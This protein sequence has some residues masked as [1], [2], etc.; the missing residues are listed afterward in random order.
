[1]FLYMAERLLLEF[2]N[3]EQEKFLNNCSLLH[4]LP[5]QR[6]ERLVGATDDTLVKK[7]KNL[8]RDGDS[9][10]FLT[11][12]RGVRGE[13]AEFAYPMTTG[14]KLR[15]VSRHAVKFEQEFF[16]KVY[17]DGVSVEDVGDLP[18]HPWKRLRRVREGFG[19]K[20]GLSLDER[21]ALRFVKEFYAERWRGL[22]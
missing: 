19:G 7:R 14:E 1:M 15:L 12:S 10:S 2:D 11:K 20:L 6:A 16:H 8:P 22:G 3:E 21:Y 9:D 13:L 18:V 5:R 4:G 17:K